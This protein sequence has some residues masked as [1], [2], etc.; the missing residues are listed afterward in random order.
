MSFEDKAALRASL[1]ARRRA[2]SESASLAER[3]ARATTLAAAVLADPDVRH[4]CDNRRVVTCFASLPT[5]PPT[6]VL[7][8]ALSAAGARVLLPIVRPERSLHW[9]WFSAQSLLLPAGMGIPEPV[10][11]VAASDAGELLALD[12]AVM[13]V[14]AL[15]VD[16]RGARLGQGGGYFDTLLGQL[17]PS[18]ESGPLIIALVG[19]DECLAPGAI[20]TEPHDRGVDRYVCA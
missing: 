16:Q 15:A 7:L 1:R 3:Q 17:P 11:E 14:P 12:P 9:A 13:L 4:A 2:W 6:S 8:E 20:P 5:E 10:G 19:V 18:T